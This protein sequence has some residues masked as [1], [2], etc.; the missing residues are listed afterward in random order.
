MTAPDKRPAI[1]PDGDGDSK[2]YTP[3]TDPKRL[4]AVKGHL[5]R[6]VPSALK[7]AVVK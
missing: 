5:K 2:G 6:G 3:D 7:R 1:T 4:P